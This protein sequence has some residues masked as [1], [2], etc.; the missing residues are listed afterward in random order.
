VTRQLL[1]SPLLP[2]TA[3]DNLELHGALRQINGL[4]VHHG[5]PERGIDWDR[6]IDDMRKER[7][8]H[9]LGS[10][11]L[12]NEMDKGG[13]IDAGPA[14]FYGPRAPTLSVFFGIEIRMYFRDHAPA[15]FHAYY[16]NKEAMICVETLEVIQGALP[17]R[18]LGLVLDW[19]ELHRRELAEN[20]R[21][22]QQ[23]QEL[24][25]IEPLE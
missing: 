14:G 3:A 6:V 23:H 8:A 21:R 17:R 4:W 11:R 24:S 19:A 7:T 10:G 18:A 1:P 16:Q 25:N 15:H 5:V 2:A 13:G 9:I 20:W 22:A 12:L